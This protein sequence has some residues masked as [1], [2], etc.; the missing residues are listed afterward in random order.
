M[1]TELRHESVAETAKRI[2]AYYRSDECRAESL[3]EAY[4]ETRCEGLSRAEKLALIE[5]LR[6][7]FKHTSAGRSG[8]QSDADSGVLAGFFSLL[9]GQRIAGTDLGSEDLAQRLAESLNSIFDQLNELVGIIHATFGEETSGLETIRHLIGSDLGREKPSGS[10]A[11]YIGQIK[12]AFLIANQAA[13]QAARVEVGK[14]LTELDPENLGGDSEKGMRFAFMRKGE[15]AEA[16]REK[17]EQIR[18]WFEADHFL[19]SYA[20]EFERACQNLHS[21]KRRAT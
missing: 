16:Y 14:I 19:E 12:E 8:A 20:R 10:L 3:I 11:G 21:E 9:L 13:R 6:G 7:Y 2:R 18:K 15:L 4:L 17:Y 1:E 5:E